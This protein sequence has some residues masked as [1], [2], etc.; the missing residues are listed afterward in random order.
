MPPERAA[1]AARL[2]ERVLDIVK[3]WDHADAA[4]G[5]DVRALGAEGSAYGLELPLAREEISKRVG[6]EN[7]ACRLHVEATQQ[8]QAPAATKCMQGGI[9][10]WAAVM[11]DEVL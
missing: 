5:N 8:Q 7:L 3:L 10:Q 11:E 1:A 9:W 2:A 4:F 6:R